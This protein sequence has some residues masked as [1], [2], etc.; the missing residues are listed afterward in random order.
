MVTSQ[1]TESWVYRAWMAALSPTFTGGGGVGICETSCTAFLL[2]SLEALKPCEGHPSESK[3]L[4]NTSLDA[5]PEALRKG[6]QGSCA[7]PPCLNGEKK[8]GSQA[9]RCA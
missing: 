8:D 1:S 9:S 7:C 5:L 4:Y 3:L 6:V 2:L